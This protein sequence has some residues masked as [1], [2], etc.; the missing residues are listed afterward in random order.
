MLFSM[1]TESRE[2][3]THRRLERNRCA[4]LL[5]DEIARSDRWYARREATLAAFDRDATAAVSRLRAEGR[6]DPS[7]RWSCGG[8]RGRP[9]GLHG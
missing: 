2:L 8:L 9:R 6:I 3:I 4:R 5:A 7:I 1:T